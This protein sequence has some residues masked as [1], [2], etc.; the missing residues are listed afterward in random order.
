[1][2]IKK[3]SGGYQ[4]GNHGKI[5][6]NRTDA[7]KQAAA[8]H[9]AGYAED[10]SFR[11]AGIVLIAP[12]NTALFTLRS[13]ECDNP[14]TWCFPGGQQDGSESP[15]QTAIRETI[16]EAGYSASNLK[17]FSTYTAKD[18]QKFYLFKTPVKHKFTPKLSDES[19][20]FV[21]ASLDNPPEPLHYGVKA[22][23][24]NIMKKHKKQK[25]ASDEKSFNWFGSLSQPL[26]MDAKPAILALDRASV[27]SVDQDGRLHVA[28]TNIS[29]ANICPYRGSEIPNGEELGLDPDKIYMLYR[30]PEELAK[31]AE[32]FNNI[33]VL[34]RH[35]PVHV[36]DPQQE[37]VI[38]STGTDAKFDS[39]YLMN[40]M[41]IWTNK[42]IDNINSKKQ[43]E[44]SCAY[45]YE[46]DMTSGNI[47][48][49]H[50]DGIM[51]NI[52]GNHVA[53][54]TE[55]RAGPDVVVGDS[56]TLESKQIMT[57][58]KKAAKVKGALLSAL[59]K[60]ASDSALIDNVL[61]GVKKSNFKM[62]KYEI[63]SGLKPMLASDAELSDLVELLDKLDDSKEAD[64][65][66]DEPV[67][68]AEDADPIDEILD[69]IR[70]KVSDEELEAVKAKIEA[71][72]KPAE[73]EESDIGEA[74]VAQDEPPEFEGKPENPIAK[75]DEEKPMGKAAMDAA[76]NRVKEETRNETLKHFRA[77]AA[78]EEE[79]RPFVG[80][81]AIA[82][83]SAE[84]VYKAA[85]ITMGKDVKGVHPSAYRHILLA[86][87]KPNQSHEMANDSSFYASEGFDKEFL[88]LVPGANNIRVI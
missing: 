41:V 34:D 84:D 45:R 59:P 18:G 80:K 56:K 26:A 11:G 65:H 75:K 82:Q 49:E 5:Y 53:I 61:Q 88:D 62:K 66:D 27:R 15:E 20:K 64:E 4:W 37:Y 40:S 2:P 17:P 67:E 48:G 57:H 8:A 47:N 68:V 63:V 54:V 43:Q 35:I 10:E 16:E 73:D 81:L 86:Q 50:F 7:E 71:C 31:G 69:L 87:A 9:A 33:P 14:F 60:L 79:V 24:E 23:L 19:T 77:I 46:P 1:M 29:K 25:L 3:V 51:R 76:L 70:G 58:S 52:R 32:T 28:I 55:G 36:T 38:G 12:D 83:D 6:P 72:L 22:V 78:A 85:L 30:D 44:I 21:W 74:D 39:P 13:D 42:A